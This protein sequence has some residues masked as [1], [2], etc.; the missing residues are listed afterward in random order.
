MSLHVY[1]HSEALTRGVSPGGRCLFPIC[2]ISYRKYSKHIHT[3]TWLVLVALEVTQSSGEND[4][5]CANDFMLSSLLFMGVCFRCILLAFLSSLK[6]QQ[7]IL[8][9]KD[10]DKFD[11]QPINL[12]LY[13]RSRQRRAEALH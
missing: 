5:H 7:D 13:M 1:P 11:A 12:T 8:Q 2:Q 4:V 6:K 3:D 9:K 10:N